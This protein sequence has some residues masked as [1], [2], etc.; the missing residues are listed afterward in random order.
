MLRSETVNNVFKNVVVQVA[1]AESYGKRAGALR[2]EQAKLQRELE[3]VKGRVRKIG[4]EG[5]KERLRH[6]GE[7][8]S[9]LI[10]IGTVGVQNWSGVAQPIRW[11]PGALPQN[12]A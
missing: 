10:T 2:Q 1:L 7:S 6:V 5:G 3:D 8:R 9:G 4:K 12:G 11:I